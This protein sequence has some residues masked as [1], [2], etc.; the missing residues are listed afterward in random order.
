MAWT[1]TNEEL[2]GQELWRRQRA[3]D[4]M[5]CY[6]LA[7][8][9]M[10]DASEQGRTERSSLDALTRLI[11]EGMTAAPSAV[12]ER[13]FYR[14]AADLCRACAPEAKA[15]AGLFRIYAAVFEDMAGKE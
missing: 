3:R 7:M 5:D 13:A 11:V 10:V 4:L 1:E 9:V 8:E 2:Q 6:S 15:K 14:R 12:D